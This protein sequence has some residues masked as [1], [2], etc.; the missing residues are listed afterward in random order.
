MMNGD[1]VYQNVFA[2]YPDVLTSHDIA[3][4]LGVSLVKVY[5][6]LKSGSIQSFKIGSEY[7]IPK[8]YVLK[9]LGIIDG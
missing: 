2:E 9:Y 5:Q 6:L 4:M 8:V 7:R 1:S 3:K